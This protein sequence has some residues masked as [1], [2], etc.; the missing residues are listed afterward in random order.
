M[1]HLLLLFTFSILLFACNSAPKVDLPFSYYQNRFEEKTIEENRLIKV[2]Q[3]SDSTFRFCYLNDCFEDSL[4]NNLHV[5]VFSLMDKIEDS[6]LYDRLRFQFFLDKDLPF[7]TFYNLTNQVRMIRGS[8]SFVNS[9]SRIFIYSAYNEENDKFKIDES[10]KLR[11]YKRKSGLPKFPPPLPP[12]PLLCP[13]FDRAFEMLK[14]D[15]QFEFQ[16]WKQN[17]ISFLGKCLGE[18]Q[19]N[20]RYVTVDWFSIANT[21]GEFI[22]AYTWLYNEYDKLREAYE[23]KGY[24]RKEARKRYPFKITPLHAYEY[25]N[26]EFY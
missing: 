8:M 6:N 11:E 25:E 22:E 20:R 10:V 14:V 23:K 24:T 5:S 26:Y 1:K 17:T 19:P 2:H 15:N 16:D 12:P 3:V 21:Y 9:N 18:E 4:H 13:D 7:E